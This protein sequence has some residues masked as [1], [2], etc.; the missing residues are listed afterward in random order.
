MKSE[1]SMIGKDIQ[2]EIYEFHLNS[3][4][5][6]SF[7]KEQFIEKR[8]FSYLSYIFLLDENLIV[9]EKISLSDIM[10]LD[11]EKVRSLFNIK[12]NVEINNSKRTIDVLISIFDGPRII[13][14]KEVTSDFIYEELNFTDVEEK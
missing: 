7:E 11:D 1:S 12:P 8:L 5:D 10:Y 2:K 6:V 13:S 9:G 14:Y 4:S 3:K